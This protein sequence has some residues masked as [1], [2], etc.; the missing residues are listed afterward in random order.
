MTQNKR[1]PALK[2]GVYPMRGDF[3]MTCFAIAAVVIVVTFFLTVPAGWTQSESNVSQ[4][5]E[6]QPR[7]LED[8]DYQLKEHEGKLA[9]FFYGET[10]PQTVFEVYVSTLPEYDRKQLKQ[11]VAVKDY[12]ELLARIEDYSS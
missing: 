9:V 7:Q 3:L 12:E 8:Y 1:K 10:Q 6:N 5:A 4:N 2:E 11:G